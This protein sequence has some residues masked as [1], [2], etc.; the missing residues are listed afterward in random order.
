VLKA[1]TGKTMVMEEQAELLSLMALSTLNRIRLPLESME[2]L[3]AILSA[4]PVPKEPLDQFSSSK[5]TR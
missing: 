1:V 3:Q 4:G 2:E 5:T